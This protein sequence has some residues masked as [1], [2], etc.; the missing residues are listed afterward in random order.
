MPHI[1]QNARKLRRTQTQAE[2]KLW[3]AL[4]KRSLGGHRFVRQVVI[5]NY[6]VDFLCR[7]KSLIIEVDGATHGDDDDVKY[8]LKRTAYLEKLGFQVFRIGNMDVYRNLAGALDSILQ[9][10]DN[11][12]SQYTRKLP[13]SP[14]DSSP[15]KLGERDD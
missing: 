13:L 4:R 11:R 12:K 10:L 6:I 3:G 2:I 7:E 1:Q 14:L 15:N 9:I 8:D 5:E